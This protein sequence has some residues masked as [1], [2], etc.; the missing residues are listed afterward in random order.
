MSIREFTDSAGIAW[1][2]WSTIPGAGAVYE[3][4]HRAGWLTFASAHTR[5]RLAPIPHGWEEVTTERLELMSRAAEVVQRMTG[6]SPL[7]PD[8]D[9]PEA[10]DLPRARRRPDTP[11]RS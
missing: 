7:T 1:R 11:E 5:K 10:S 2:V 9:A 4:S 8:P 3:E 6:A